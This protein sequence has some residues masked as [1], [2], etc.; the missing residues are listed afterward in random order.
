MTGAV[1]TLPDIMEAG[2]GWSRPLEAFPGR[3]KA[4]NTGAA[5]ERR[6]FPKVSASPP[7]RDLQG[8]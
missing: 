3:G 4:I 1:R 2:S 5:S 8:V 6:E 7:D